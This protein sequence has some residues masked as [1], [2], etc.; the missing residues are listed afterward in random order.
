MLVSCAQLCCQLTNNLIFVSLVAQSLGLVIGAS[1]DVATAVYLGPITVIPILLFSGWVCHTVLY[2]LKSYNAEL[3]T[4]QHCCDKVV[5][6]SGQKKLIVAFLVMTIFVWLLHL[7]LII[8]R[9][10]ST[11]CSCIC[12]KLSPCRC[13][14]AKKLSRAQ[15]CKKV[16][17]MYRSATLCTLQIHLDF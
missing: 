4:R 2:I 14:A 3:G 12:M 1:A 13:S 15:L 5:R 6:F 11:L 10:F 8:C 16:F 9:I 7:D 17:F